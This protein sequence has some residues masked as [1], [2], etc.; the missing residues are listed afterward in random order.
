MAQPLINLHNHSTWSDGHYS[1]EQLVRMGIVSGLTHLGISDHYYTAKLVAEGTYVDIDELEAYVAD[2]GHIA[3][4]YAGQI[5]VLAGIEVDWSPRAAGV[6]SALWPV[7]D[8]LDYVL[9]EYVESE[10]WAGYSLEDLLA[11]LPLIHIPVGLAHNNLSEN[12][13]PSRTPGELVS[14]LQEHQIFVELSTSPLT[15]YYRDTD[16]YSLRLWGSLVESQV[17]F[18]IGSDTHG[19]IDH[20]ANVRDAH[21]FLEERGALGRLITA[22]WDPSQRA[23]S[24]RQR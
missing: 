8:Q 2:L 1:P 22:W 13:A 14:V 21:R 7:I 9:F 6:L 18:S 17:R 10:P 5:H 16:P 12:F 3:E 11:V 20:V 4:V 15:Q 23:W 24:D 19:F